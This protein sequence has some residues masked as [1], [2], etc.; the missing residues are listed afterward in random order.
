VNLQAGQGPS[1]SMGA[2][3]ATDASFAFVVVLAL[4]PAAAMRRFVVLAHPSPRGR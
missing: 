2:A 4:S 3:A 1:C